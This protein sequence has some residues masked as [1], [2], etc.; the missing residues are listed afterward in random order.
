MQVQNMEANEFALE[1][2]LP[3]HKHTGNYISLEK[4]MQIALNHAGVNE[5]QVYVTKQKLDY[6]HGAV[7]YE[8]EFIHGNIEY[9]YEI[10][11]VTGAIR[12]WERDF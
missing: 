3:S 1:F 4:A 9:E 7:V 5:S 6:E 8:I 12:K 11:A 10:D 2:S